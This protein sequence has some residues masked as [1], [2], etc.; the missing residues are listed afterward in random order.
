MRSVSRR[1]LLWV[2][3]SSTLLCIAFSFQYNNKR[4]SYLQQHR[5]SIQKINKVYSNLNDIEVDSNAYRIES[6]KGGIIAGE[7]V[8]ILFNIFTIM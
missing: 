7:V 3:V 6:L 2:Y 8:I 1:W 4:G 5:L